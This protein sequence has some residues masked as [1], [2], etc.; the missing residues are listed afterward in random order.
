MLV[1]GSLKQTLLL[2]IV[3]MSIGLLGTLSVSAVQAEEAF[4]AYDISWPQCPDSLPEGNFSFAVIGLNGGRPFTANECFTRQYQ[5]ARSAEANPDVYINL[6]FPGPG[7]AEAENGPYGICSATDDW[8]RGYNY[9]FALARDAFFRASVLGVAPQRYWFDVEMDN[10]WSDSPGNNSQV[11]R[12]ALDS[13][14]ALG[15]PVG[16]YGTR[17]QWALITGNYVPATPRPLWVAGAESLDEARAR[18]NQPD[19]GFANGTIWI[20]QFLVGEFDENVAC[21]SV[22]AS[23]GGPITF[24]DIGRI[25]AAARPARPLLPSREHALDTSAPTLHESRRIVL[26]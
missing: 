12:G 5:W 21:P 2:V 7:R 20:V 16:I 15:V 17:Y 24:R 19:F 23:P 1:P 10:Y 4:P 26:R 13:F 18:C 8:C 25:P 14:D 22:L 9:G 3:T 11:V 6:D